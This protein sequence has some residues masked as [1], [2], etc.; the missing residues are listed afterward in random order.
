MVNDNRVK[1]GCT[2]SLSEDVTDGLE[3]AYVKEI[4]F[5]G[6]GYSHGM[7]RRDRLSG[8]ILNSFAYRR[9]SAAKIKNIKCKDIDKLQ[10]IVDHYN[11]H[12]LHY[13][14]LFLHIHDI[15]NGEM[16]QWKAIWKGVEGELEGKGHFNEK[17]R[18]CRKTLDNTHLDA[19][20]ANTHLGNKKTGQTMLGNIDLEDQMAHEL[21]SFIEDCNRYLLNKALVHLEIRSNG[22]V[23]YHD[24]ADYQALESVGGPVAN[25]THEVQSSFLGD[26]Q[27]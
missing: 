17:A 4:P 25:A 19:L 18:W 2:D 1:E 6:M 21:D 23:D 5:K 27:G 22:E 7:I 24:W 14:Y 3:P 12:L 20:E 13:L 10:T 26:T 8:A 15:T 9:K 11:N 16:S